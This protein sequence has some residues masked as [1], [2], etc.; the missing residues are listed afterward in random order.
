MYQNHRNFG[1][2]ERLVQHAIEMFDLVDITPATTVGKTV[3][4][5]FLQSDTLATAAR[6]AMTENMTAQI[7]SISPSFRA[8][9]KITA[10]QGASALNSRVC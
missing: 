4:H 2:G 10:Q 6:Y 5:K 3:E 9:N 7:A 1:R 8:G